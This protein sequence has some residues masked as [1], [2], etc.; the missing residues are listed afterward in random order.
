[1]KESL[2]TWHPLPTRS[3]PH[4]RHHH[5][6]WFVVALICIVL[7]LG[8]TG[9]GVG[10]SANGTAAAPGT[11]A[12]SEAA[13]DTPELFFPQQAAVNGDRVVMEAL[14]V[15]MLEVVDSC[16]RLVHQ[17]HPSYLVVWPPDVTLDTTQEFIQVR[18][19]TGQLVAQVG[20]LVQMSGG[21]VDTVAQVEAKQ[22]LSQ[23]LPAECPGP[24]WIVGDQVGSPTQ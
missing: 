7:L 10:G 5:T 14:T 9:C 24:Y 23:P 8:T 20:S 22:A 17:N 3:S 15:G 4:V 2:S 1:M 21:V 13:S 11:P 16:I 18:T 6:T 12:S 19:K